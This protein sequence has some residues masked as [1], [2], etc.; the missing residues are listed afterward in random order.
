M[1]RVVFRAKAHGSEGLTHAVDGARDQRGTRTPSVLLENG[2]RTGP[3]RGSSAGRRGAAIAV[4]KVL[5]RSRPVPIEQIVVSARCRRAM[6]QRF[7]R[8]RT[9]GLQADRE[10]ARLRRLQ[11][12]VVSPT[13][14]RQ[15]S[16][17][18]R[19]QLR[20]VGP[21]RAPGWHSAR[22]RVAAPRVCYD[23]ALHNRWLCHADLNRTLDRSVRIS[24]KVADLSSVA[25]RLANQRYSVAYARRPS[26][27]SRQPPENKT[28]AQAARWFAYQHRFR[29]ARDLFWDTLRQRGNHYSRTRPP[30]SRRS[31]TTSRRCSPMRA[32]TS[33]RSTTR[34]CASSRRAAC[35][36]TTR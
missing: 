32:R 18:S 31:S 28:P 30:A 6:Q 23:C 7:A 27:L 20:L 16:A 13:R 33:A 15:S 9:C 17:Q 4:G 25:P 35:A 2:L 36:S 5:Y 34:W 3:A 26:P 11:G 1:V 24:R 19:G 29:P 12:R 10:C 8:S 22:R 21:L 14:S